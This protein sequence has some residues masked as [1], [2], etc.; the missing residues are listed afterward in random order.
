M[1]E[2]SFQERTEQAT[3]R[4]RQKAREEGKVARS[5]ELNSAV[6]LCL[7]AVTLYLMGPALVKQLQQF[8]IFVFNEAPKM[9]ADYDTLV[10]LLSSRILTFLL[11]LGPMLMVLA[12]VAYGINVLQVGFIISGKPIEPKFDVLNVANGIKRIFSIRSLVELIRDSVKLIVIGFVGYKVIVSQVDT[13]YLLADNSV[14]VFA[15]A[16][17]TLA[18]KTTLQIGVVMLLLALFDYGFQ[19]FDYEKSIRMSK[20]EILDEYKDTEGSPQI[21]ARIRQ[22]QREMSRKRMMQNI[23][24]A[25]VVITNPTH[26]AVALKYN[27]DEMSAPMVVAKGERLIAERIKEIAR[28]NDIPIVENRPLARA[29]FNMCE[30]GSYVPANLYRAVA[31]V[32]AYVYRLKGAKV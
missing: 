3:P 12:L 25:N 19:R 23:P 10:S 16:M 7:G 6:I 9:K 5:L 1:A 32:L 28:E 13:Y 20:Q 21:K 27:P 14:S 29:L 22:I 15:G 4:R 26:L 24:K 30:I 31:E 2:E 18:L 8:M 17:G 11:L